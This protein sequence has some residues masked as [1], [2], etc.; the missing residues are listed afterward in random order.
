MTVDIHIFS[1][2]TQTS[3]QGVTRE[4]TKSDLKQVADSYNSSIHEAP[5]RIGHEDSDKVPAWGWVKGVKL[6]GEDL[7]AEV[8][9]S[10]L[11]Q[12][13][14]KNGLYKKVSASFYAPESKINPEPGQWSLRHVAMLGAQ[15][16]AVKGLSGFAYSEESSTEGVLDFAATIKLSPDQVFDEELGPTLKTEEA[17][18]EYLK[19]SIEEA[20]KEMAAE[21]KAKADAQELLNEEELAVSDEQETEFAEGDKKKKKAPAGKQGAEDAEEEIG[22]DEGEDTVDSGEGCGSKKKGASYKEKM[23]PV[24]EEDSDVDND[25]DSDSSDEY[26]KKRRA[27]IKKDMAK[28]ESKNSEEDTA[29]HAGCGNHKEFETD[30]G[31]GPVASKVKKQPK[32]GASALDHSEIAVPADMDAAQWE[33]G[34]RD[35]VDKFYSGVE[36]GADEVMHQETE[37]QTADYLAGIEAGFE[38]AQVRLNRIGSDSVGSASHNDKCCD[39]DEESDGEGPV[40]SKVKKNKKHGANETDV[41]AGNNF[42]EDMK[43]VKKRGKDS[44][45]SS[46]DM[47]MEEDEQKHGEGNDDFKRDQTGKTKKS[48]SSNRK[49]KGTSGS[50]KGPMGRDSDY[51]KKGSDGGA[52]EKDRASKGTGGVPK[53]DGGKSKDVQDAGNVTMKNLGGEK[54]GSGKAIKSPAVRVMKFS[55]AQFS[56]LSE[57]LEQ[58]EAMNAKLVAEK[59][60]AE[61]AAHRL[62]LEEFAESLYASGRLTEATIDQEDLVDYMEGLENGTLEF[63]EGESPA[64]KLMELLAALPA[65][66]SFSEIAPHNEEEVPEEALNPHEKA[67][68]MSQEEGMSYT[69]ALKQTLFSAE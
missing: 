39:T 67:L 16:P 4:F 55:E 53:Q 34:F 9:F 64:T 60:A 58:L 37:D 25:G 13:Y 6:K 29:D 19:N 45:A 8:D 47:E 51:A 62:Q 24:G 68:R 56:E 21:E 2:G 3:A 61:A 40:A 43:D 17:P 12:D 46:D 54:P 44:L 36:S 5:I 10:P 63:S 15:P 69:E 18:L 11:M 57:R 20:R 7:Y 1:P 14:V 28:D 27:A 23:D 49:K 52:Q 50:G 38:F 32:S 42:K 26:L 65:Q 66:V 59:Q 22:E 31:E 33:A 41:E 30:D 48:D 35:A